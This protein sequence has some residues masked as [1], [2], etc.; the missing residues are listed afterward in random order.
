MKAVDGLPVDCCICCVENTCMLDFLQNLSIK[1]KIFGFVV[2][3]T[4]A[5]GVLLTLLSLFFI[6]NFEKTTIDNFAHALETQDAAK[7]DSGG[8]H[9]IITEITRQADQTIH[10]IEVTLSSIVAVVILLAAAGALFVATQ[11]AKPIGKAASGLENISSGHADLT[12]RLPVASTDETG[13]VS[14]YFNIFL[15]KLQVIMKS[16]QG[17]AEMLN[18]AAESIHSLITTIQEKT[19]SAKTLSQTVFR[20]AG[21]QSRDM[22]T[23]A[24]VIE[25]S[26]GNFNTISSSVEEL[27][28]TVS[29]IAAT[30]ARA[31]SNTTETSSRMEQTLD[32]ISSLGQAADQIGKV[33]ETIS[34]IS[35]QVNLLALNATIEAARAGA[36]GKGFAVVANE[37]KELAHQVASAATEIKQRIEEVQ[38]AAQTTITEIR[39]A[40]EFITHNTEIVAT[41][42]SAVEEQSAT[43]HEIAGSLAEASERLGDSNVKV[44]Q[45]SVYAADMAKMSN[46]V[47]E[48]VDQVDAA[49]MSIMSTSVELQAMAGKSADTTRQFTT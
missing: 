48:A 33:T 28:A 24:A 23:I 11:I 49:V 25:E 26:T 10:T 34:E 46:N 30:A 16:L 3:S 18:G 40:A 14:R 47:T 35:D 31:H 13:K 42:A 15:E 19:S 45:A 44:S 1:S 27:N 6:N 4:I 39:E 41:I 2:P 32:K 9:K 36:A 29:E 21:Y 7:K 17:D 38:H 20:S 12:Q 8:S 37:I 22:G 43:V 5:F